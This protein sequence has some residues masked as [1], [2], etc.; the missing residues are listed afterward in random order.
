MTNVIAIVFHL[1]ITVVQYNSQNAEMS[2]EPKQP[3]P[4]V[5]GIYCSKHI[6][7]QSVHIRPWK[8]ISQHNIASGRN[9][10]KIKILCLDKIFWLEANFAW[11]EYFIR[12][13]SADCALMQYCTLTKYFPWTKVEWLYKA[14]LKPNFDSSNNSQIFFRYFHKDSISFCKHLLLSYRQ[15]RWV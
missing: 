11:K 3:G 6:Y 12:A 15:S 9:I 10:K 14:F 2:L 13:Q 1:V 8:I 5:H 4:S 7:K